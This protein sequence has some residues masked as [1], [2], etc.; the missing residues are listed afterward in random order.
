VAALILAACAPAAQEPVVETVVVER[1]VEVEVERTV[2]VEVQRTVEVEVTPLPEDMGGPVLNPDVSGSI[3]LWHFWASPVRRNAIR[4]VIAICQEK[5]PNIQV[6]DTVKPFGDIWTAN[7]AAVAAGS[8][9]PDVIVSDRPTLP[10]DAADGVYM[11]LQEWAD[12]DNVTRDQFYE[13]AWDQAVADGQVYGIP[14]ET[15]VRVLF[16]NKQLFEATG[17]DPE[18]P[19]ETW[20]EV[21]EYADA[22]DVQNPDGTYARLGF[23]PLLNAGADIWAYTNDAE[24][25]APDGTSQVNNENMI[26]LVNWIKQWIDRY[27]GWQ[28][29]QDFRAQFGAPPNDIFMSN[30]I[31]MYADIFGYNSFLEF[32]RPRADAAE[33]FGTLDD[34][35]PRMDWGISLLPYNTDPGTWSGGFSMSI[36]TGAAN[37]DAAWEFIKCAT[38]SEAQASWARDTQAQPTNIAAANDPVTQSNPLWQI[39]DDALATST[40]GVYLPSYPN[41]WGTEVGPRLEQVWTGELT[42]EE[43]LNQAQEAIEAVP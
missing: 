15:D 34:A 4:R 27:G 11:S 3:E 32:Y 26:E 6:T 18:D 35:D 24:P 17:L 40:G 37:A 41:Y 10:K 1:T 21:W 23:F 22:L 16:Y 38:G 39:V 30:G 12:R 29:V 7:I 28:N 20:D 43:A 9:M 8:G 31:A 33:P 19:P 14:H 5:L 2:E 42:A 25:V 36:P 13:W